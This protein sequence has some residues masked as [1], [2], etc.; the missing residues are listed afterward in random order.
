MASREVGNFRAE[1][2][3]FDFFAAAPRQRTF[4]GGLFAAKSPFAEVF[5][6]WCF[7]VAGAFVAVINTD[8]QLF[9]TDLDSFQFV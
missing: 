8:L 7:F 6:S 2:L 5:A 4:S 1:F 3:I 9:I